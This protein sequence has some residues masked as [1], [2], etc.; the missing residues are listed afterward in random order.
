MKSI[1]SILSVS[2]VVA[3]ICAAPIL[4][5]ADMGMMKDSMMKADSMAEKGEAMAKDAM[6]AEPAIGGFCPT[7][8]IHGMKMKGSPEYTAEYEG[9]TYMFTSQEMKDYFMKDPKVNSMEAQKKYDAEK[10]MNY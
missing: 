3:I 10:M 2:A 8:L 5:H 4:S 9:K 7:C 6:K 1:K